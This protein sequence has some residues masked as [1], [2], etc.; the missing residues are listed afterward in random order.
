[1]SQEIVDKSQGG[2]KSAIEDFMLSS[3]EI[4]S[5]SASA[6]NQREKWVGIDGHAAV[7]ADEVSFMIELHGWLFMEVAVTAYSTTQVHINGLFCT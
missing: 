6:L 1:M 7:E 5:S 4:P 3:N 2:T